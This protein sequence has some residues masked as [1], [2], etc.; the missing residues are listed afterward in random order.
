MKPWLLYPEL[1][2]IRSA[3]LQPSWPLGFKKTAAECSHAAT[4]PFE[5]VQPAKAWYR[6]VTIQVRQQ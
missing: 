5:I 2:K 6:K 4:V 1:P 3:R